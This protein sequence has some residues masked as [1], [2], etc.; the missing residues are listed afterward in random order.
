MRA[1]SKF[2]LNSGDIYTD[3]VNN[4]EKYPR[5]LIYDVELNLERLLWKKPIEAMELQYGDT[6]TN[7]VIEED[8]INRER[9]T[10]KEYWPFTWF[11]LRKVRGGLKLIE[12]NQPYIVKKKDTE[13]FDFFFAIKLFQVDIM[14]IRSF[15]QYH[16]KVNFKNVVGAFHIFLQDLLI[17]YRELL[18]TGK[19][20]IIVEKFILSSKED[21][22]FTL[23]P[24]EKVEADITTSVQVLAI[25]YLLKAFKPHT[26]YNY[27]AKARF[28]KMLTN[29]NYQNI[30]TLVQKPLSTRVGN[31]R[32][33][34]RETIRKYFV[35]LGL[36]E[37]LEFI[38]QDDKQ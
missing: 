28:I 14:D 8:R 1:H 12:Y 18:V 13:Y 23:D 27:S 20:E 38:S 24:E 19:L 3:I 36:N 17:K 26:V 25:H 4:E 9:C 2:Y 15:L 34:D 37:V 33:N 10:N 6:Y 30:Y 11:F 7:Q 31:D 5:E 21:K 22:P 16:L 29:K 35:D 32:K